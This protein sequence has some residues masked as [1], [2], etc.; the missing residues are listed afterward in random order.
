M[1][2]RGDEDRELKASDV[3][4]PRTETGTKH[5]ARQDRGLS[6]IFK[7]IASPIEK[8]LHN[9]NMVVWRQTKEENSSLPVAVRR[10]LKLSNTCLGRAET[11]MWSTYA[12][13]RETETWN[14][15]RAGGACTGVFIFYSLPQY[16]LRVFAHGKVV[17][18]WA[19]LWLLEAEQSWHSDKPSLWIFT[20]SSSRLFCPCW[21]SLP[22]KSK[23]SR[24]SRFIF[25]CSSSA[26]ISPFLS[27][28]PPFAKQVVLQPVWLFHQ[29]WTPLLPKLLLSPNERASIYSS[30]LLRHPQ[31]G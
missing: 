25:P 15:K 27:N 17:F 5:F 6:R 24:F 2:A 13:R 28:P 4:E 11:R 8:I 22:L 12:M 14:V 30:D 16:F 23:W 26:A 3:L 7:L 29:R 18:A 31:R 10:V 19:Y 1:P 21:I 9:I 20:S